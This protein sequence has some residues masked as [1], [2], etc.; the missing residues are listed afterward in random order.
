M[1]SLLEKLRAAAPQARDQRDRRRRARLKERHQVRVASGQTDPDKS[2]ADDQEKDQGA[3]DAN[4]DADET[5]E[6]PAEATSA[7]DGESDNIADRAAS[8]LQGLRSDKDTDVGRS[9]RR[10]SAEEARRNR[11][12]RR[13]N[14]TT[15]TIS[16]NATT[17]D[18]G[19]L[20]PVPQIQIDV[21]KRD[22]ADK[23]IESPPASGE[24]ATDETS[25]R[26]SSSSPTSPPP[27]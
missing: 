23:P 5:K 24:A 7:Q 8:M 10:D 19:L 13:R 26:E 11:R 20:S 3:T 25:K 17:E 12:M 14:P 27:E 1:D 6:T 21:K 4:N 2:A 9:R 22:S 18:S 15:T 16:S